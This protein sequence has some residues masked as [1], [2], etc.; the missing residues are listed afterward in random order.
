VAFFDPQNSALVF[1]I[2]KYGA[3][4]CQ[5]D[6]L[7]TVI[8]LIPGTEHSYTRFGMVTLMPW[9]RFFLS[10]PLPVRQSSC[11][12]RCRTADHREMIG[13]S[14]D[15]VRNRFLLACVVLLLEVGKWYDE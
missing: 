5:S 1:T 14:S 10:L 2:A 15:R 6:S 4:C 9:S 13:E 3:N 8:C 12:R 11:P 7:T